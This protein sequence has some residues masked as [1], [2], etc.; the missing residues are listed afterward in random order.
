MEEA[1]DIATAAEHARVAEL[2]KLLEVKEAAAKAMEAQVAIDRE[3]I[4]AKNSIEEAERRRLQ[5]ER[6]VTAASHAAEIEAVRK[7]AEHVLEV[8]KR[9]QQREIEEARAAAMAATYDRVAELEAL[10]EAKEATAKRMEAE[11]MINLKKSMD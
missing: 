11:V 6:E 3:K 8:A 5:S 9:Q 4:I 10:L 2:E 7:Q 1:R